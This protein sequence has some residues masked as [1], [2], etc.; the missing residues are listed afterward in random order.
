MN[1]VKK[2]ILFLT[3]YNV[4]TKLEYRIFNTMCVLAILIVAVSIP[5]SI[6]IGLTATALV[7]SSLMVALS[8]VYYLA[9]FKRKYKLAIILASSF[10]PCVLCA[11][12]FYS[13]GVVGT[14]L[15]SLLMTLFLIMIVIPKRLSVPI[16]LFC[17][18]LGMF[19]IAME[20][21]Y[22]HLVSTTYHDRSSFYLDTAYT[23]F[24]GNLI[25]FFGIYTLKRAYYVEKTF[26]DKRA[27][28]LEML[29][30]ERNKLFSIVSHDLRAPLTS[31]QGYLQLMKITEL[32]S[33][34][35]VDVESKLTDSVSGTLQMLDN[36]LSWSKSQLIKNDPVMKPNNLS[37]LLMPLLLMHEAQ[38]LEKG[39]AFSYDLPD[40][41]TLNCDANMLQLV[42]RNLIANAIKFTDNGG[43][44]AVK[45]KTTEGNCLIS[46]ADT[47]IGIPKKYT[48]EIF[49]LKSES[50]F[51][52]ANEKGIGLGL[53]LSWEYTMMQNG[54]IWFEDNRGKGT[55]FY[56]SFSAV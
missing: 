26:A 39:L 13:G 16:T 51:G 42:I 7:M 54:K 46:I 27:N 41:I 52:T 56:V 25:L 3:E 55:I 36:L 18:T 17:M 48:T 49:S 45:V 14:S 23:H 33:Q 4:L 40:G 24:F 53:Y 44:I 15:P 29:N 2:A 35:R 11:N 20:Y 12:F 34:E 50:R 31:I 37:E 38:A 21:F 10:V 5:F 9:R 32:D 6:Y 8:F 30:Q 22:P 1:Q 19:V 47:G 43:S 28:E